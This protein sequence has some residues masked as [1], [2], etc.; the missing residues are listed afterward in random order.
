VGGLEGTVV[1]VVVNEEFVDSTGT[2]ASRKNSGQGSMVKDRT[3]RS[4]IL[5]ILCSN[6]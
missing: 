1:D 4:V 3:S 2:L 5:N 6:L